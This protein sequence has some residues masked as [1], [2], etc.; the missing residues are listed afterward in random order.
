LKHNISLNTKD[1]YLA[2]QLSDYFASVI[3]SNMIA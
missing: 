1:P 3:S 2:R